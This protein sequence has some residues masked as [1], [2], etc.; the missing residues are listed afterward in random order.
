MAAAALKNHFLPKVF[1]NNDHRNQN[2]DNS[3]QEAP[4]SADQDNTSSRGNERKFIV[5]WEEEGL[6]EP[7]EIDIDPECKRLGLSSSSLRIENFNLIKTLGTGTSIGQT[8]AGVESLWVVL[9]ALCQERLPEYGW[10]KRQ[11]RTKMKRRCL[12]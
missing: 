12:L 2:Q 4:N 9:T 3:A 10:P 6:L 7:N 5:H 8:W 1:R 11:S